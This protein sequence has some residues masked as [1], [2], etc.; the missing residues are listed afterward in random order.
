M[1][2]V[3]G[4]NVNVEVEVDV[5][6]KVEGRRRKEV[7]PGWELGRRKVQA[8]MLGS[9]ACNVQNRL[10]RS[11]QSRC[12]CHQMW[13]SDDGSNKSS[14]RAVAAVVAAGIAARC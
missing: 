12:C 5:Y 10:C 3:G 11:P 2:V 6:M 8:A 13:G 7:S 9:G 14:G 1:G 4:M